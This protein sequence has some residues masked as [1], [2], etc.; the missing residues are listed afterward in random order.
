MTNQE[1]YKTPRERME[2]FD[3][4]CDQYKTCKDCQLF[5]IIRRGGRSGCVLNWLAQESEEEKP[6]PCPFCGGGA[7]AVFD[8]TSME[9][10]H[11]R[12][13][14]CN[15]TSRICDT[16]AEAVAAWNRRVK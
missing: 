1:R 8:P 15:A 16:R 14:K 7:I 13:I 3:A 9:Q 6:L 4:F 12:C 2:A 11:I 10:Q 5:T